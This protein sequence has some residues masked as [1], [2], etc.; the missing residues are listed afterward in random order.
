MST[1]NRPANGQT[2]TDLVLPVASG[3]AETWTYDDCVTAWKELDSRSAWWKGDLACAVETKGTYGEHTLER[4]AADVGVDYATMRRYKATSQAFP[5]ESV[6]RFTYPWTVYTALAA[7]PDRLELLARNDWTV[8]QARELVADRHRPAELPAGNPAPPEPAGEAEVVDG[9]I[10]DD[11]PYDPVL[12]DGLPELSGEQVTPGAHVARS[13]G[14]VEWYTPP[15]Y[16]DAAREVMGGIDL[17]PASSDAAN[18]VVCAARYYTEADDGLSQ[19]WKGRVWMN[20]PYANGV[21]GRFAEKLAEEYVAG[22]ITEAVVLVNNATETAWY[23]ALGL[24][25]TACCMPRGRIRFWY[26]GRDSFTPLQ[27]QNFLYFGDRAARFREVF[28]QF[29]LTWLT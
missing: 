6:N 15:E 24:V 17:D 5:A 7:Q 13:S 11:E 23:Q 27:G 19:E 26:P 21:I 2:N 16:I 9:E 8:A 25:A 14:E 28:H 22:R 1:S 18:D 20:P 29:G 12:I 3:P 10:A 4:F